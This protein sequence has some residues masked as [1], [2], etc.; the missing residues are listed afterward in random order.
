MRRLMLKEQG[1]GGAWDIKR[2]RG[3]LVELEFVA[4]ILQLIH[5]HRHPDI[6]DS[7]TL[8]ALEKLAA[9]AVLPAGDSAVLR[10][11]CLLYQRLTQ[12]LRLCVSTVYAP[13]TATAGLN[14]IVASAAG[15]PDIAT[16]E[17]LLA[18]TEAQVAEIFD[19]LVG[20]AG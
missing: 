8:A 18:D 5:A 16:A 12:V 20:P 1:A 10:R 3:G 14:R 11:A 4:Q 2:A 9:A 7:N 6:L 15:S 19:R 13:A 17:A